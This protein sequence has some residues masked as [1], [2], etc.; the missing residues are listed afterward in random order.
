MWR[1]FFLAAGIFT[2]LVGLETMVVDQVTMANVRKIPKMVT[3]KVRGVVNTA[4]PDV[5][6]NQTVAG[7]QRP[8]QM[9]TFNRPLNPGR[10]AQGPTSYRGTQS[11][12]F[13]RVLNSSRRKPT[14]QS[15]GYGLASYQQRGN[16]KTAAQVAAV[17]GVAKSTR[18][19]RSR[20]VQTK[21]WMP[22][23]LLAAG[24]IIILY[25]QSMVSQ[26]E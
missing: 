7:S 12:T 11:A 6:Q 3:G 23:S 2:I 15:P 8:F 18:V 20:V 16:N 21:D 24:T 5:A 9:P 14:R 4:T 1:S 13:N 22:W 25:T 17:P 26:N 10:S 19:R